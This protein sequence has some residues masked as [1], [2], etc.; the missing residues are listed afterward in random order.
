MIVTTRSI[1]FLNDYSM[2]V[3]RERW[4]AGNYP[5]H[6]MWGMNAVAELGW[7]VEFSPS[8]YGRN[9]PWTRLPGLNTNNRYQLELTAAPPRQ[10][11]LYCGSIHI[12]KLL[13]LLKSAGLF[14]RKVIAMI[15]HPVAPNVVNRRAL[16][17]ADAL[18]YLNQFAHDHTVAAFP[19]LRD[20][21][22]VLGWCVDTDFYDAQIAQAPP[23]NEKLII[24]AGKELRD[25]DSLVRGV[26]MIP[27]PDLRVEI[28][29]SQETVPAASDP[30]VTVHKGG[31]HGAPISYLDLLARYR[32]AIAIAI[33]M[34]PVD[35]TVGMTSV[36]DGFA[37]RR[38]VM[39][40]RHACIDAPLEAEGLGF[41][42]EPHSAEGWAQAIGKVL[43][44]P[45]GTIAMGERGRGYA[46]REL[47]MERYGQRL[48]T[49][50][51]RYFA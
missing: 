5:G 15:H 13:G 7:D 37:A 12:Y 26:A 9:P 34:H 1:Y 28:Y 31:S 4:R 3:A 30:R 48:E 50:F 49:L 42:V 40:T 16:A 2:A 39:I 11:N 33:P 44:D 10:A 18:F 45:A 25:Y 14:R 20:R 24:A 43:A 46:E 32:E 41:F 27:D 35:R 22:H 21:S 47:S 17:A 51:G 8:P 38:A 23:A 19:E 29:C 36:F 6:H